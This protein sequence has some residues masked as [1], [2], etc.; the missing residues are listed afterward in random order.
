MSRPI[1]TNGAVALISKTSSNS[2]GPTS[3]SRAVQLFASRRSVGSAVRPS[4][5]GIGSRRGPPRSSRPTREAGQTPAPGDRPRRG[6]DT[7]ERPQVRREGLDADPLQG[8]GLGE[9]VGR[10][11]DRLRGVVD[12]D[13]E[14]V[15]LGQQ[16]SANA[17]TAGRDRKSS[18]SIRNRPAQ[19]SKSGS[20]AYRKAASLGKRVVTSTSA[21]SL[22]SFRAA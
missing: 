5:A 4:G 13:V 17:T 7:Q 21:P 6:F 20:S 16:A 18:P 10:P 14:G 9:V 2:T 1:S 12:E 11:S 8:L 19:A 3:A 22:S 15:Q